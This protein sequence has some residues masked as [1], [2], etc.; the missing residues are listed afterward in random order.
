ME[1]GRRLTIK[2]PQAMCL[3]SPQTCCNRMNRQNCS[4]RVQPHK[5]KSAAGNAAFRPEGGLY[6]KFRSYWKQRISFLSIN[7]PVF[8]YT[9]IT[10]LQSCLPVYPPLLLSGKANL[11]ACRLNRGRCTGLIK[12]P[13][14]YSA[15][16]GRLQEH[17]G[18]R[19]V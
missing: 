5:I 10:V 14:E 7:L 19:T 13:P 11:K 9:V 12:I 17:S 18:F 6:P 1:S 16:R 15:F 2:Q 8:P 4:R 3:R